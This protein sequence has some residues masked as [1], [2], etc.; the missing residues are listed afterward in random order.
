MSKPIKILISHSYFLALDAKEKEQ[1]TPYPPLAPLYLSALIRQETG[2]ECH[3]YDVMFDSDVSGLRKKIEAIEPTLVFIYDDDFNWLTKMCL[4][5]MRH[6]ILKLVSEKKPQTTYFAHG[7]DASDQAETYLKAGFDY[8]MHRN[9]ESTVLQII[10]SVLEK[11]SFNNL[12]SLSFLEG[13]HLHKTPLQ[14]KQEWIEKIP[15]ADWDKINLQ[16]YRDAWLQKRGFFSLNIS[17]AHGCPY[18]CNWCAKPLYGRS[19]KLRPAITVAKEFAYIAQKIQAQHIWVTDDIFGLNAQWLHTFAD[20]IEKE[21][22]R[23][24]YKIQARA[25]LMNEAY[26]NDLKRSGCSEVWLGAESGSQKILDAM[27]KDTTISQ[28]KNATRALQKAG[29]KTAFFLQFGYPGE[30]YTDI[31]K[32]LKLVRTLLPDAIGISVSYPLPGT[33]FYE[34]VEAELSQKKNWQH[35]G[36]L[37]LL[38]T[39]TYPAAFYRALHSFTHH[40]FGF[41]SLKRKQS[42][43]RFMRRLVAQYRH[44]PGMLIH[45]L[46][47]QRFLR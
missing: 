1:N 29:I 19:Y 37:D 43:K 23:I 6:A 22:I 17:T 8:V 41:L 14:K 24:P 3:F 5:N 47:M 38:H 39:S 32:T 18:R 21:K 42:T 35:S 30:T 12:A 28:I 9:A 26:V 7:S 15:I 4:L 27:E 11:K 2:I 34:K 16:P 46:A 36:D 10:H 33:P 44:I 25:D 40:Y 13:S 31:R 20:L 45:R